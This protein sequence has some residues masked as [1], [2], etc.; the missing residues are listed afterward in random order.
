M[1][2]VTKIDIKDAYYSVPVNSSDQ[3]FLYIQVLYQFMVLANGYTKGPRKFTKLLK[4]ALAALRQM[5]ITLAAYLDDIII[6]GR[7]L[8]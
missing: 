6:F 1:V 8:E 4:P 2:Y 7:T 5:G 3:K